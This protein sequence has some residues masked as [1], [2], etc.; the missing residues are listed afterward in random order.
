[1]ISDP[2]FEILNLAN[3]NLISDGFLLKRVFAKNENAFKQISTE[4]LFYWFLDETPIFLLFSRVNLQKR[5]KNDQK[6]VELRRFTSEPSICC[7]L[8]VQYFVLL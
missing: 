5:K 8:K 7:Y 6:K 1:L 4:L 3:Q 2:I